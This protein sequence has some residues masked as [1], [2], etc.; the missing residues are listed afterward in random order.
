M[1]GGEVIESRRS[2]LPFSPFGPILESEARD[3]AGVLVFTASGSVEG[4]RRE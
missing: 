3:Q 2:Y 4:T 1:R